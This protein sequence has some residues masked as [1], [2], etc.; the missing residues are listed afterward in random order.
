MEW[1]CC[2]STGEGLDFVKGSLN[3][4][5]LL[6]NFCM[7]FWVKANQYSAICV[8]L[9]C[10]FYIL[11][12]CFQSFSILLCYT[13]DRWMNVHKCRT[14]ETFLCST[15]WLKAC[16]RETRPLN[17]QCSCSWNTVQTSFLKISP[18]IKGLNLSLLR[19]F[20]IFTSRGRTIPVL[21]A[22]GY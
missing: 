11:N 21:S 2:K 20:G 19:L 10:V 14:F 1:F 16:G 7:Y 22:R 17:C 8:F 6:S 12:C 5:F 4:F 18:R 15:G 13:D 9:K 3:A